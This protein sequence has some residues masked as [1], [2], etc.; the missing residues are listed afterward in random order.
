MNRSIVGL[1]VLA[2]LAGGA[3]PAVSQAAP[4]AR[5]VPS[6]QT[7]VVSQ[8]TLPPVGDP[9]WTKVF[10][11]GFNLAH[12]VGTDPNDGMSVYTVGGAPV[13]KNLGYKPIADG[14][15]KPRP[16]N[17]CAT[18][19]TAAGIL[20]LKPFPNEDPA[21]AS[22]TL[23]RCRITSTAQFGSGTYI[24]AARIK[25]HTSQGHLSSFWL[26]TAPGAG[27]T[28]EIDVIENSGQKSLANGCKA[29]TSMPTNHGTVDGPYYGLNHTYYSSY[30]PKTGYKHCLSQSA[31][32]PLM[33]N[34]FHTFHAEWAPGQ[35]IKFYTDGVLSATYGPQYA[36]DTP[37]NAILTNIDK[38]TAG[39]PAQ[40]FQVN[41]VKVWKK[42]P[43]PPPPAVCDN[44][45]WRAQLG[46]QGYT[47]IQN[48]NMSDPRLVRIIFD[49]KFYAAA[50]PD[51]RSWAEGKVATQGGN[52]YD[53][54][55]WHW[56]NY[57]IPWGRAGSATFDPIYYMNVQPDVSAAYGWNN[58]AGAIDHF[59]SYGRFEGRRASTF[60]EP[61]YYRARYGDLAGWANWAVL[62]HFTVNGM[63]EGRQGS[64]EFG[65]AYYMG[66]YA[67][68]RAAYGSNN[69]RA[70]MSHWYSNGRAEGRVAVP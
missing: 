9:S 10:E 39:N 28:N 1:A 45:C 38:Q 43:P 35:H 20:T 19:D 5:V 70:G 46:T 2:C 57:G 54:V 50:Y 3:S 63:S 34:Q 17:E 59:V 33:D 8:A 4:L 13:W 58:Y 44:D 23:W 49:R 61:N 51:V 68:L 7:A 29:T 64:A 41:W 25:V 16:M 37:L 40:D 48:S 12:E 42:N 6:V 27:A 22:K 30:T 24:F 67:D 15:W 47:Y 11:D 36:K 21:D 52:F 53:H 26:N 69:Y 18:I 60:F 62:D 66:T 56:L 32:N 14:T 55:Q 65:P 31:T